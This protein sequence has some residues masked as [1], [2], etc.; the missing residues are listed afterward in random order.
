M[1]LPALR[2]SALPALFSATLIG[3]ASQPFH[4]ALKPEV[5]A[6]VQPVEV[7]VGVRQQ[8]LYATFDPS[9]AG[10]AAASTCGA[11]PGI[12]ILLAA[13]CGGALGA[14]DASVNASRAKTAEAAVRPLKDEI[15]DLQFDR[16]ISEALNQRLLTVPNLKTTAVTVTKT[17]D[18]KSY[19]QRLHAAKANGV[20]FVNVD[21]HLSTDF[22]TLLI[23]ARSLLYPRQGDARKAAGLTPELPPIKGSLPITEAAYRRDFAYELRL[24]AMPVAPVPA[25]ATAPAPSAAPVAAWK[26]DNARLLRHGLTQG[27][28]ELARLL[29]EDLQRPATDVQAPIRKVEVMPGVQGDLLVERP[30]GDLLRHP[31]GTLRFRAKVAAIPVANASAGSATAPATTP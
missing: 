28:V 6:A 7:H 15:V 17:V 3:C 20:M 11:I 9:M 10:A 5:A 30:E 18:D 31:D 21:Y 1:F 14:V 19:E 22:S 4:Q 12:G 8:E 2:R 27:S 16:V 24:P 29:A 13:A 25:G 26:A 23:S